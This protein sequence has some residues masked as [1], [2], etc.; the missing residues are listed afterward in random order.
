MVSAPLFQKIIFPRTSEITMASSTDWVTERNSR[1]AWDPAECTIRM[2]LLLTDG[3]ECPLCPRAS[4]GNARS[5]GVINDTDCLQLHERGLKPACS[6]DSMQ[7][8]YER[9]G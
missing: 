3:E 4:K 9:M 6:S 8:S 1:A 5:L 2:E 7:L